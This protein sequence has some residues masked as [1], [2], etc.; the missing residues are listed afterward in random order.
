MTAAVLETWPAA[1]A[2]EALEALI[3]HA[4][5]ATRGPLRGAP[6]DGGDDAD[7]LDAWLDA[8]GEAL[9]V[10]TEREEIAH[11]DLAGTL[12]A[13]A[14]ALLRLE[15]GGDAAFLA[16]AGRRRGK[17]LIVAPDG[18]LHRCDADAVRRA[19]S[20]ALEAPLEPA[21][22]QLLDAAGARGVTR[23]RALQGLLAR[24]LADERVLTCRRIRP[25]P[26]EGFRDELRRAGARRWLSA[27]LLAH[28]AQYVLWLLSWWLIGHAVLDGEVGTG[29]LAAWGLLL[30]L[31]VP[32]RL[33]ADWLG[34]RIAIEAGVLLKRRLLH[35]ALR[36]MP[37]EMRNQG[38]GQLLGRVLESEAIETL[39]ATGG[40]LALIAAIEAI[41]ALPVLVAGAA[42]IAHPLLLA[43]WL[44]LTAGLA[45]RY[46]RERGG[47]S[48]ARL[49][50]TH[51]LV[52][53]MVGH[54]TR[55]AQQAPDRWHDGEAEALAEYLRRSHALDRSLTRLIALTPRGWLLAALAVLGVQIIAGDPSTE[56]LAVSLGGILLA[57]R[58]LNVLVAGLSH[59]AGA[60]VASQQVAP[61]MRAAA[62]PDRLGAPDLAGVAP[63]LIAAGRRSA[64]GDPTTTTVYDRAVPLTGAPLLTARALCFRHPG[65]DDLVL[66]GCDLDVRV[67]DRLLLEGAS[68]GGK[69]TLAS[70]LAGLRAAP[71]GLLL[72][73]GLDRHTLGEAA[74]GGGRLIAA[75]QFHENHVSSARSPSTSSSAAAG[76]RAGATSQTPRTSAASSGL[77]ALLER[78]PAGLSRW[79]G[80]RAGSSRTVSAAAST[81]PA[82]CCRARL[83]VLD[84]SFGAL[85]PETLR[86]ALRSSSH[87]T[88][89]SS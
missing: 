53:R 38:A 15:R 70:L 68:G 73:R 84:E 22:H 64:D 55:L 89:P 13:A 56:A 16:L 52:E 85:D 42:P 74:G 1:R 59:L 20:E 79:W 83:L 10:V 60:V 57:F 48:V 25:S 51:D 5:L 11:T 40:L 45:R 30:A 44:A 75:P 50:M 43:A 29:V 72:L 23:E 31:L 2:G 19:L 63:Q 7:T 4:G 34:G 32:C 41:V 8:Y 24:R 65:R 21:I 61:L 39:A 14:P 78:M 33:L 54:R 66:R 46:L 49:E 80:R 77:G 9:G 12:S 81:S 86:R 37:E 18:A 71:S 35:G 6:P 36:L 67:G 3:T 17:L 26:R 62:R 47:W 76:R 82:R 58:A 88:P 27:F 69:S 28:A 87:A